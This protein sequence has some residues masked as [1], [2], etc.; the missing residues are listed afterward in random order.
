[1]L[2]MG[3]YF[4]TEKLTPLVYDYVEDLIV[5]L[6]PNQRKKESKYGR[7]LSSEEISDL[8]HEG[9]KGIGYGRFLGCRPWHGW[10]PDN[11]PGLWSGTE[12]RPGIT[13]TGLATTWVGDKQTLS[14]AWA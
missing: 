10:P 6:L 13:A 8:G 9:Q 5:N 14:A 7:G 2:K 1:M 3:N 11:P 4:T 12:T